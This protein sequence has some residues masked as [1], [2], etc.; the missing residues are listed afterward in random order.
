MAAVSTMYRTE[1]PSPWFATLHTIPVRNQIKHHDSLLWRVVQEEVSK[2]VEQGVLP[3]RIIDTGFGCD[4]VWVHSSVS[5][6]GSMRVI[7]RA[8]SS[9]YI[10]ANRICSG[11]SLNHFPGD[12][13]RWSL[14][15]DRTSLSRLK[16][17]PQPVR[18][19]LKASGV[20]NPSRLRC[21]HLMHS[22]DL[23]C[24]PLVN[25]KARPIG[26]RLN[27]HLAMCVWNRERNVSS[28]DVVRSSVWP[29]VV[30]PFGARG[31]VPFGTRGSSVWPHPFI[32]IVVILYAFAA[33]NRLIRVTI[34]RATSRSIASLIRWVFM[35]VVAAILIID[36]GNGLWQ[37][38]D[39]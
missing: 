36:M 5:F 14:P 24:I 19:A 3:G 11:Q 39:R 25:T 27:V 31:V 34:C 30:V 9:K 26:F 18:K 28:R 21:I 32:L 37:K 22:T 17:S 7:L 2:L 20:E 12:N 15:G 38:V 35:P 33:P 8:F 4:D 6:G 1:I 23:V 16:Y 29:W 10:P 13:A